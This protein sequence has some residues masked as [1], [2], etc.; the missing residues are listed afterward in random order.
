MKPLVKYLKPYWRWALLAPL[1][2]M[3]EVAMDLMQ[4]RLLQRI[5]DEGITPINM[6]VVI[7]TGGL[8]IGLAMLGW[9]GGAGNGFFATKA[10]Q[11]FAAD[12][13]GALFRHVQTL[14]FAN[15]DRLETGQLVTRLTNDVNHVQ[16]AVMTLLRIL[17]RAPLLML[18]GLAM[19]VLTAPQLAW[20]PLSLMP[21]LLLVVIWLVRRATPM[22]GQV[23]ARLDDVNQVMEE[24]LSGVRVIKAFVRKAYEVLRFGRTNENLVV[25]TIRA[26]RV[27]A[28]MHPSMIV[29]LNAGIVCVIWFGGVRVAEGSMQV[30]QILAF[31]NYLLQTLFSLVMVSMLTV[32]VARA[33][34]SA[35]RIAEV[36][37]AHPEVQN[38]PDALRN[39]SLD[40]RVAF[41]DV[42]FS[43]H[44]SGGA[45]VLHDV[46][47]AVQPG[48]TVALLGA[49]GSGKSSLVHLIPRF[50]D[51]D[52]GRVTV[53]GYDVR[54]LD[55]HTLRRSIGIATQETVLFSGTV[56]DNIRYG[57]PEASDEEV[58]AA[59]KVAQA[60]DFIT[61]FP[62]GYD[63]VVGQRGVNLSGGQKQRLAIA[64]AL[65]VDPPVLILDDS[66]SS[67]DVETE[68]RI[69]DALRDIRTDRTCIMIAQRISTVLNADQ[70]LVQDEGRIVAS[71][72]HRELLATSPLYQDIY[73]SQLG[74]GDS[75][76][77]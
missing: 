34:A 21:I 49:T 53:G 64:R 11:G 39:V 1:L 61:S 48:Q 46:S 57:R 10:A 56:R 13:R 75:A 29:I 73:E 71:G 18:G 15:L 47:F 32:R 72:T 40:G 4:P 42:T 3:F 76:N 2:M 37:R 58:V 41:E 43:Y 65:L 50:Y 27:M 62:E 63:T 30:G 69:Q 31:V 19:A 6:P 23:Q 66:T 55:L 5:V 7:Q 44:G 77:G 54:D 8:M 28:L 17:I 26:M 60:H 51:P 25:I 74:E 16:E 22:F 12:L 68:T 52:K 35:E 14:S 70:I 24:N 38:Q 59:A 20:I 36:L 67:V 33:N 9:F 45:P